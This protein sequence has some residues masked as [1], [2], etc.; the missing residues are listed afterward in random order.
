[1]SIIESPYDRIIESG[2]DDYVDG[3][4]GSDT[5]IISSRDDPEGLFDLIEADSMRVGSTEFEQTIDVP[6]AADNFND[7]VAVGAPDFDK[8]VLTDPSLQGVQEV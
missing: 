8:T 5:Q 6:S 1:M 7:T 4:I 2:D 3:E